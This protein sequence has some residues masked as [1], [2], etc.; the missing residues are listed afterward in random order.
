MQH[1]NHAIEQALTRACVKHDRRPARARAA[2]RRR[3]LIVATYN[4]TS[5]RRAPSP[6]VPAFYRTERGSRRIHTQVRILI[7]LSI[8]RVFKVDSSIRRSHHPGGAAPLGT[9]PRSVL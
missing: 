6:A 4:L 2:R 9:R 7:I 3:S 1:R 8:R 5:D